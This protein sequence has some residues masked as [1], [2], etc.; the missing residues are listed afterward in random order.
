MDKCGVCN[1]EKNDVQVRFDN[2]IK[3]GK[4]C[5]F[6]WTH[7]LREVIDNENRKRS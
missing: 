4:I 6:C 1:K 3:C 5:D 7:T 2:G